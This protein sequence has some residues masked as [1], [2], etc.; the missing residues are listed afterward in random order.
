MEGRGIYYS[1]PFP[2]IITDDFFP[3][4]TALQLES[5]FLPYHDPAWYCYN[6]AIEKKKTLNLWHRFP[7]ATYRIMQELCLSTSHGAV[8]DI[9]L[10]G[11]GWHIM[12]DGGNLNPHL[13]YQVHPKLGL[14]RKWNLII[15]LSSDYKKKYGGELGFWRGDEKAPTE[16]AVTIEP[17]FNRAVLFDTTQ[18]SWHGLVTPFTA[19]AGVYR[20]SLAVY[21]TQGEGEGRHKAQFYPR[22]GQGEEVRALIE[23]RSK[24]E[25]T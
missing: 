25:Y 4:E 22:P 17:K 16:L 19:P 20:K 21:Y 7:A 14:L 11:A 18:N 1:D 2:Y 15:Y 12:E 13:D 6:N 8:A 23:R 3:Y 5:E 9:G 24:G 10:H